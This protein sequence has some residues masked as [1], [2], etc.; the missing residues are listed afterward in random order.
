MNAEE[1]V[2]Y[3]SKLAG[4]MACRAVRPTFVQNIITMKLY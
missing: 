2:D 4:K 3:Y 1:K